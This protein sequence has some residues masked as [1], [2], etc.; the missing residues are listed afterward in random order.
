MHTSATTIARRMRIETCAVEE[1]KEQ[2]LPAFL[3]RKGREHA[4]TMVDFY[5]TLTS[6]QAA[7]YLNIRSKVSNLGGIDGWIRLTVSVMRGDME[8]TQRETV[9]REFQSGSTRVPSTTDLLA[10]GTDIQ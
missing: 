4:P 2:G 5:A 10:R 7:T 6:T 3:W 8:Q 9:L 1:W